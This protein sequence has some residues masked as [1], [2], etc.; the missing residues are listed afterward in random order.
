MLL[1]KRGGLLLHYLILYMLKLSLMSKKWCRLGGGGGDDICLIH[2]AALIL[3]IAGNR[4]SLYT[5]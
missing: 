4:I 2:G 3:Y 1:K 5:A